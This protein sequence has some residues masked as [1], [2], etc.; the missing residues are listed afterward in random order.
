MLRRLKKLI[1]Q[2]FIHFI[3]SIRIFIL[4]L[5]SQNYIKYHDPF[6]LHGIFS[7]IFIYNVKGGALNE[8]SCSWTIENLDV[9]MVNLIHLISPT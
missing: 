2:S 6:F 3:I 7:L 1:F 9:K 8:N 5:Y 4:T